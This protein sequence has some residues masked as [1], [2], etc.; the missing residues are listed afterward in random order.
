ME[1]PPPIV[2]TH[3]PDYDVVPGK[4]YRCSTFE[5]GQEVIHEHFYKRP[6]PEL[7]QRFFER[8]PSPKTRALHAAMRQEIIRRQEEDAARAAA[9]LARARAIF[10]K[11]LGKKDKLSC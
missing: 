5:G 4:I 6:D 2:V 8:Y 1:H 11:N 3:R 9:R 7:E 10:I